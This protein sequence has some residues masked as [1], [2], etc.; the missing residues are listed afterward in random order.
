MEKLNLPREKLLK[1][2]IERLAEFELLALLLSTG[3][4]GKN[5][6]NFSKFLLRRFSSQNFAD[7]SLNDL[8]SV[9]GL[10]IAKAGKLLAAFE[11]SRRFLHGKQQRLLL[12][13]N[14]VWREMRDIRDKKKEFFVVFYL[15]VKSQVLERKIVSVGS[16]DSSIVHPREVFEFAIRTNSAQIVVAHNHPSGNLDP[17]DADFAVT[18]RLVHAGEILGI[19]LLDHVIVT[20][21]SS[22]SLR[23]FI[24]SCKKKIH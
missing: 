2:G 7:I 21:K 8:M 5:V 1:Y 3:S 24:L 19:E 17:S 6:I 20:S 18:K 22:F 14:A 12:S 15:D 10:G 13:R 9:N 11:L 23:R 4:K 16:L